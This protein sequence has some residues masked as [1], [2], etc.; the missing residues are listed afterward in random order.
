[1]GNNFGILSQCKK[2]SLYNI[3]SFSDKLINVPAHSQGAAYIKNIA[4][5][6]DG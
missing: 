3:D 4:L 5:L 1:M 6:S 2:L